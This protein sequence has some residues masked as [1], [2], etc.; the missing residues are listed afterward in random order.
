MRNLCLSFTLILILLIGSLNPIRAQSVISGKITDEQNMPVPLANVLISELSLGTYASN[1]GAF[2]F[3]DVPQGEWELVISHIGFDPY[4]I[5]LMVNKP[6]VSVDIILKPSATRMPDVV[7]MA[8]GNGMP[9]LIQLPVRSSNIDAGRIAT[10][11]AST[12]TGLLATLPGIHIQSDFGM[13]SSSVVNIR[14]IGSGQTGTLVVLDGVPLN[15]S[16]GGSVNW[17]IIDKDQLAMVE[18]IK[19]PG[20]ALFGSNAMGGVI[21]MVTAMPGTGISARGSVS[22]GTYNTL[23]AKL[24]TSGSSTKG[25]WFWRGFARLAS[26]DGYVNTPEEIILENDSIVVPVFLNDKSA[27]AT[28]GYRFNSEQSLE[29]SVHWFED[30]RGRGVKIYEELGANTRRNTLQS[31]VRYRAMVRKWRTS[32]TFY[33]LMESYLRLNEYYSDGE[34][35]LFE[36]DSRRDDLGIRMLVEKELRSGRILILG[37]ESRAGKVEATDT[38]FTSTDI[39]V[40]RGNLDIYAL[41]GQYT[42]TLPNPRWS[43][44]SGLRYDIAS[45]HHA[46]FSIDYPSYSIEYFTHFQFDEIE[47]EFWQAINPKLILVFKPD[48]KQK[49]YVSLA[50]GFRAPVLDDMCRT[51]RTSAGLR[52]AN[53]FLK[54]E[55]VYHAEAGSD[56]TLPGRMNLEFSLFHTLGDQF[57]HPLSNGDSVNLGYT[58]APVFQ[59]ANIARVSITGLEADFKVPVGK[60]ISFNG[61]YTYTHAIIGR[62]VPSTAADRDLT[63][64]YLTNIPTHR[65]V[66]G[67]DASFRGYRLSV[68]ARYTGSRWIRDDNNFDNIYL[69]SD[70]YAPYLLV[71][72][73]ALRSFRFLT[74]SIDIENLLNTHYINNRGYLS[75]GRI[76]LLKIAGD[77]FLRPLK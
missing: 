42:L 55:H 71:D 11:P 59:V 24:S 13:Y 51:S 53:P 70:R 40:N 4:A 68:M 63:G 33:G 31:A 38:Y 77:I 45:F 10:I 32:A 74:V 18:V 44:I 1:S 12:M 35:K 62:F 57:M 65:A 41:F 21:N 8:E 27:G 75:P 37:V 56:W 15:K 2:E 19:G 58:I 23:E 16:D 69:M 29:L 9:Y 20:S 17:N 49:Y 28:V 47:P 54:P 25:K 30:V 66:A 22:Y 5:K 43:L 7:I 39:I 60:F 64:K 52:A 34:Y 46:A 36:A 26:S 73:K 67:A 14:G 48:N 76:I 50:K 3:R 61:N 6:I 72:V